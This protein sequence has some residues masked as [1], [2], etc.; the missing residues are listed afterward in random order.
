MKR[1]LRFFRRM[2]FV[3]NLLAA[4]VSVMVYIA[5]YF[6][7]EKFWP[8]VFMP[9]LALPLIFIHGA[10]LIWWLLG[11]RWHALL[12][13]LVLLLGWP[14]NQ[15]SFQYSFRQQVDSSDLRVMSYNIGN[16]R[17]NGYGKEALENTQ[18]GIFEIINTFAPDILCFQEYHSL[19]RGQGDFTDRLF[20][21]ANYG[22]GY[23]E[24]II[25]G[26]SWGY[27]GIAIFSKYPLIN[28]TY[29]SFESKHSVNACIYADL[30]RKTDTLRII[31]VHLQTNRLQGEELAYMRE[32]REKPDAEAGK[33]LLKIMAK[34]RD[35]ARLRA[36]QADRVG[37]LVQASPYPVILCGDFND[38][39]ASYAYH[40]VRGPLQDTF[41]KKGR[42]TGNTYA[43][44]FPSF[45]IDQIFADR[46]FKVSSQQVIRK[47]YSDHYPVFATLRK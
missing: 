17:E 10:F 2:L 24:K 32:F 33:G 28:K 44:F 40:R 34:I 39:P 23:F 7:P 38:L 16:F 20:E 21:E 8:M 47:R 25:G 45:R 1:L 29:I 4:G 14:I 27:A 6:S 31:N 26:K 30:V 3:F 37:E 12:S 41:V 42:G 15:L 18:Q 35:A 13:L 43:G 36:H 11:K 46:R 5:P 19:E 22:Y 9:Y